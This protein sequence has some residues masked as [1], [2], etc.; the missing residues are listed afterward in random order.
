[1]HICHHDLSVKCVLEQH[2]EE[3]VQILGKKTTLITLQKERGTELK[4]MAY[5]YQYNPG[6]QDNVSLRSHKSTKSTSPGQNK[7]G[8]LKRYEIR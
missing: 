2:L 6:I 1:M 7:N 4:K 3:W 5:K 8:T